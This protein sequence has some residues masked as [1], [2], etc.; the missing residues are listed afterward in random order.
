MACIS[1]NAEI[2]RRYFGDRSQLTNWI[3]YSGA[4]CHMTPGISDFIL[5]SL[6]KTDK[7]I[8]FSDR[9]FITAKQTGEFQIK[10]IDDNGKPFIVTLYNL[11]LASYL[12]DQIFSIITLTNLGHT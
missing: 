5:S 8:E 3:L 10:I 6:V 11:L 9:N 4:T 12:C 1:S 2:P 7:S